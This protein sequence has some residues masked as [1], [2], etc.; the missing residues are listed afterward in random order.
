MDKRT[1]IAIVLVVI[2][3]TVS[4]TI[5]SMFFTPNTVETTS[6]A[7][8][9]A[10]VSADGTQT[11]EGSINEEA[12][13]A[14]AVSTTNN[15]TEKFSFETD[16]YSVVFD[17]VGASISSLMLKEHEAADGEKVDMI[18]RGENDNNAF[19]LYWGDDTT[20]PI[21]DAFSYTVDGQKV[22]FSNSYKDANGKGFTVVKTFE[23]KDGEY[24][25][26]VTVDIL[27]EGE[28]GGLNTNGYA[29]TLA[30]EP[31]V[32]PA[33]TQMKN[34]AY[35]Y[36]RMY[37]DAF[38]NNGKLKKSTVKFSNGSYQTT[39]QLQWI[40]VTS[41][42]FTVVALPKD[43]T[44]SYKYV[45]KQ[46][47]TD[48]IAQSNSIYVSRPA[49]GGSSEDTI[50]FYAGPQLKRYLTSYYSGMDNSWG[51]RSTNLDAAM[52]AGSMFSW[53][54]NILKWCLN[55]LYKVVPNYGVGIILLTLIIKLLLWPLTKKSTASTAKMAALQPKMKELQE[56][57]KDN[58][59]K[60]NQETAALYKEAGVSPMGGCLPL[61]L[62]FPILIA[63]YGLL[64]K[65][66]ELRGA[67]FIPGWIT[68]LSVP[69]TVAT[70]G[71]SIPFLGNEIHLLPILYTISMIFS[72]KIT[73][74]QQGG[75]TQQGKGMTTFMTYVM[76][77]MFFFILYSAPSGLLLYWSVQNVLSMVQQFYTN[78]R[79]K[80][81]PDAFVSKRKKQQAEDAKVPEA[82]RK[83]QEK[84]KRL[85]EEKARQQKEAGK[86][87]KRK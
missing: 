44:L 10:E 85:E 21:L 19:L 30:Y 25:F 14:V 7:A 34:S 12:V 75:S 71:F 9:G 54:E 28:F 6:A 15:S 66:F 53:L 32:G 16:L 13:K 18:F 70:L 59:Q 46:G 76:P 73:Q 69:E 80:K 37:V 36:R 78:A 39:N 50:Y 83:Y 29:Y 40:S 79:T 1:I 22:I 58:P 67:M 11:T 45:A 3:I 56:K 38:K 2:V 82:V 86:Q 27:G 4:M 64:N 43:N 61:L 55:I 17:P 62:Q 57:Y 87:N 63:M 48:E 20:N 42:Y 60:L 77:I 8:T 49:T 68:D 84:L 51:L 81:D 33:F 26:A 72:M 31:Q 52:E 65:H 41:K 24:L 5:Q 47:S 35:D 74:A 23:F